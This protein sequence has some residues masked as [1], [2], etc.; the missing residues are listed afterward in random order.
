MPRFKTGGPM[1]IL[2][3]LGCLIAVPASAA[4]LSWHTKADT[5]APVLTPPVITE[6]FKPVIPCNSNTTAGQIGCGEHATLAADKELDADVRVIF[7]S[8]HGDD[9]SL[10]DF[11]TA[12]KTWLT[13]RAADCKSQSDV[14]QGG[15]EQPVVLVN[16]LASDDRYR[17]QDLKA[18]YLLLTQGVARSPNFP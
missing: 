17:R 11:I 9:P 18:F 6:D 2:A 5:S 8:F 16:C 12:Q 10:G 14:Y 13:Y 4:A 15:T 3:G 1:A 7:N